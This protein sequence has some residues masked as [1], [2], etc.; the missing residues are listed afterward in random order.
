[1]GRKL[2]FCI[3]ACLAVLLFA[4]GCAGF[5]LHVKEEA[6]GTGPAVIL[7]GNFEVRNMNYD[8]FVAEE[9]RDALK[10]EFFRKGYR[11]VPLNTK[12]SSSAADAQWAGKTCAENGG[13]ILIRGFISQR[14]TGFLTDRETKTLISFTVFRKDG[15]VIAEGFYNDN[16]AAGEDSLRRDAA[17]KLVS[18]LM[19]KLGKAN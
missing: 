16:R 17:S 18:E 1:M 3:M 8:P 15:E 5:D 10:Y 12:V 9:F 2:K 13:D 4:S 19:K 6:H 11:A 7:L 14:E